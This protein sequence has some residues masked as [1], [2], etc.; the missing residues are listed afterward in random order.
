MDYSQCGR[1]G[2]IFSIVCVIILFF[3]SFI[4]ICFDNNLFFIIT[5]TTDFS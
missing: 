4:I 1:F 3:V 5:I 2:L